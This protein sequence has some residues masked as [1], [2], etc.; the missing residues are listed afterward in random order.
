MALRV[1]S[2]T[3]LTFNCDNESFQVRYK[4]IDGKPWIV[5]RDL[6]APLGKTEVT[7][8][9][10]I[11][12][13]KDSWKGVDIFNTLRGPQNLTI[14]SKAGAIRIIE[15]TSARPGSA[16]EK[17]QDWC[18]ERLDELITT[19]RVDIRSQQPQQLAVAVNDMELQFRFPNQMCEVR[20]VTENGNLWISIEDLAAP[21]QKST[22]A[23]LAQIRGFPGSWMRMI[24]GRLHTSF[25]GCIY[26]IHNTRAAF[27]T[28][29]WRFKIF[30]TTKLTEFMLLIK[31]EERLAL[32][33]V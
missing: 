14:V 16:V 28:I 6:A 12:K 30:A 31:D 4:L 29:V 32:E 18:T 21:L 9:C 7:I 27:G 22:A 33:G 3:H 20:Y 10:Q 26:I 11:S 5:A 23:V 2:S 24:N 25:E 13:L 17:F 8:R 1:T 19:G 15:R